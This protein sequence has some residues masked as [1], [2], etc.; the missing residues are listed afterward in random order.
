MTATRICRAIASLQVDLT[1]EKRTQADL[2]E[3]LRE[4]L[5]DL[6]FEREKRFGKREVVDFF[7]VCGIVVEVKL[8]GARK[9]EVWEQLC[10]YARHDEVK[11]LILATN[12]SMGL[13]E[14]AEGKPCWYVSLGRAWL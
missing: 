1:S 4:L 13:P 5:P 9:R 7:F 14:E 3:K 11:G 8:K 6:P 10:R 12:L 2:A